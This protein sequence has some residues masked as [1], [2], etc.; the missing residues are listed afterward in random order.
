MYVL[1]RQPPHGS[2][3]VDLWLTDVASER[4]SAILRNPVRDSH[5]FKI[6]ASDYGL[7]V[8]GAELARII[9][10]EAPGVRLHFALIP[11]RSPRTQPQS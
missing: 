10:A 4:H 3:E 2:H 7:T 11:P 5:E 6:N 8:F 9:H 1:N